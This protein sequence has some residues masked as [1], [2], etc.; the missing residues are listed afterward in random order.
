MKK[1]IEALVVILL[2]IAL[3]GSGS[4]PIW[5]DILIILAVIAAFIGIFK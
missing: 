4:L 1:F 5:G 3:I 2:A